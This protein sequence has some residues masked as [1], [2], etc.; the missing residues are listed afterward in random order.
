MSNLGLILYLRS[1]QVSKLNSNGS[2]SIIVS[3]YQN[4]QD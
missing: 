2:N 3:E 1:K 4:N